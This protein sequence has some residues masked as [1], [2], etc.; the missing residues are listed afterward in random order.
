MSRCS[1][2]LHRIYNR[3]NKGNHE[4]GYA[5]GKKSG[6][7]RVLRY[8]SWRNSRA[9]RHHTTGINKTWLDGDVFLNQCQMVRQCRSHSARTQIDVRYLTE[10]FWLF[11]IAFDFF[12]G[13]D[14]SDTGTKNYTNGEKGWV[15]YTNTLRKMKKQK[16]QISVSLN[17]QVWLPHASTSTS[18][19]SCPATHETARPTPSS[20]YSMWRQGW[21]PL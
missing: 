9:N 18:T 6:G 1:A 20:P 19:T 14:P 12:H 15:S 17:L 5:Y 10:G 8:R 16:C 2:K 13:I 21:R 3:T 11:K 7:W 4:R